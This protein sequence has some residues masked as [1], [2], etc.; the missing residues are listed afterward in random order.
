[1][2]SS[3]NARLNFIKS[4]EFKDSFTKCLKK[5]RASSQHS[6]ISVFIILALHRLIDQELGW[7]LLLFLI[8]SLLFNTKYQNLIFEYLSC[9]LLTSINAETSFLDLAGRFFPSFI[10]SF[11]IWNRVDL[12][13]LLSL[14]KCFVLIKHK[15]LESLA[16]ICLYSLLLFIVNEDLKKVWKRMK[17]HKKN[18]KIACRLWRQIPFP[19]SLVSRNQ[20][21]IVKNEAFD[22]KFHDIKELKDAFSEGN[23][24]TILEQFKKVFEGKGSESVLLKE[25]NE[26]FLVV[27][28]SV[29]W[30]FERCAEVTLVELLEE[31]YIKQVFSVFLRVQKELLKETENIFDESGKPATD[32]SS[33]IDFYEF[34]LNHW[35]MQLFL[36]QQLEFKTAADLKLLDFVNELI[37]AVEICFKKK[38]KAVEFQLDLH[39]KSLLIFVN[40]I[41]VKVFLASILEYCK[42]QADSQTLIKI[43]L[44][45]F[46]NQNA[47]M[48]SLTI[49]LISKT[50]SKESASNL[51][52]KKNENLED[53]VKNLGTMGL[54]SSLIRSNMQAL[55]VQL[56]EIKQI[57]IQFTIDF[58]FNF[59]QL[60]HNEQTR[61][62]IKITWQS[63]ENRRKSIQRSLQFSKQ[64][65]ISIIPHSSNLKGM[66]FSSKNSSINIIPKSMRNFLSPM[67]IFNLDLLSPSLVKRSVTSI[68]QRKSKQNRNKSP[69]Y[70]VTNQRGVKRFFFKECTKSL[71]FEQGVYKVL[72]VDDFE[73]YRRVLSGLLKEIIQVSCEFAKDGNGA[74]EA[75]DSYASQGFMYQIIF[76]D[77]IMPKMNGFD[78]STKIRQREK[79]NYYPRTFICAVSGDADCFTKVSKFDI[80]DVGKFYLVIRPLDIPKIEAILR[81]AKQSADTNS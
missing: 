38:N 43:S 63:T 31:A 76:M 49:C 39:F 15:T 59:H 67:S 27:I 7:D 48:H 54:G 61:P 24:N 73:E 21:I 62:G 55:G 81:H 47:N 70:S 28:R 37:N 3:V 50:L 20:K 56:H 72:I 52:A 51:F 1:M 80:D 8:L 64:A 79:N 44:K 17:K 16:I 35:S 6:I 5:L 14:V 34:C 71:N 30:K 12:I 46:P 36:E 78:A 13:F 19:V 33:L 11:F 10:P 32:L 57:N 53:F 2:E 45:E 23:L 41:R 74:L 18:N 22:A 29:E 69:D 40:E 75:Y 68:K 66:S 77:L 42:D 25:K 60:S 65:L 9:Q 58:T 26:S 4:A